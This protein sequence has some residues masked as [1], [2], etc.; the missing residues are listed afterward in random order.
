[1][2]SN[3][4]LGNVIIFLLHQKKTKYGQI[5]LLITMHLVILALYLTPK[6][7]YIK[8]NL[9]ITHH[10]HH[11]GESSKQLISH[12]KTTPHQPYKD[13]LSLN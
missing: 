8:R 1:M 6:G 4:S 11:T 10:R 13:F 12:S 5:I 7:E 3:G 2:K 9:K